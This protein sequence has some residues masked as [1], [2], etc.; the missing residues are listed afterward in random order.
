MT[1]MGFNHPHMERLQIA[2]QQPLVCKNRGSLPA[3]VY[4]VTT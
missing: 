2:L 1:L 3:V 4:M